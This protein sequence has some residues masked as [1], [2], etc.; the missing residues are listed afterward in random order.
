ML[1]NDLHKNIMVNILKDIYTDTTISPLL[2]FK[3][4]TAAYIFYNLD[5]FSTDLDFDLLDASKE[6]DVFTRI[7]EI[8]KN[9]G[10][11]KDARKK[12]FSLFFLLSYDEKSHNIKVEINRRTFG[13][14]YRINT[15]LGI[16]ML[17]MT[18]ED[19]F[20]HKLVAMYERLG[21]TNR[22]IYD[23]Y[24]F[25]KN[26][27]PINKD[28]VE[29]RSKMLFKIF[30]QKCIIGLEK[31]SDR[32]ILSGIGELLD[33]K[34]KIWVKSKLKKETIFLLKL[35]SESGRR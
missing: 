12:R 30:L 24:F 27:W 2:G 18:R 9:Y 6:E 5:R 31:M 3:G 15:Y 32:N 35:M 7:T 22:D 13:S 21:K 16:S 33:T 19:M 25:L 34:Q 23:V 28:I 8:I 4:D 26:N 29:K 17:V 20:A 1:N 10:Q 11:I 14:C